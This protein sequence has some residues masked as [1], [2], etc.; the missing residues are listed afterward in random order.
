VQGN[1]IAFDPYQLGK[2]QVVSKI[3]IVRISVL[4]DFARRRQVFCRDDVRVHDLRSA[5]HK[6]MSK[7]SEDEM[8][9]R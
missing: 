6:R 5:S 4:M 7:A 1:V 9:R 2:T 3:A 8:G